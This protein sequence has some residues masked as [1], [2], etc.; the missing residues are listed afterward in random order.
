MESQELPQNPNENFQKTIIG[1]LEQRFF[2]V[3]DLKTGKIEQKPYDPRFL[4]GHCGEVSRIVAEQ[5]G[6]K[7]KQ[8]IHKGSKPALYY[9]SDEEEEPLPIADGH[10]QA[11]H[12]YVVDERGMVWDPITE[13]FGTLTEKEYLKKITYDETK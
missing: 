7:T 9:K 1:R 10:T 4:I 2:R 8:C 5:V 11:I 12:S 6:G 13:N 3:F